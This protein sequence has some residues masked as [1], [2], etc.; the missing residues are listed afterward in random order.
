MPIHTFPGY[1]GWGYDGVNLFA[2]MHTYGTPDEIKGFI[3][4]AHKLGLGVILDVVYNHLGPEKNQLIRYCPHYLSED[5]SDWGSR[6]NFDVPAVREYCLTNAAYWIEEY[7]FDGLRFDASSWLINKKGTP[8][9]TDFAKICKRSG[10]PTILIAENERLFRHTTR[11]HILHKIWFFISRTILCM[12][13]TKSRS[14][15][16]TSSL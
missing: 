2:P 12:A 8:I 14:I 4:H 10:K 11:I 1:F 16:P 15:R 6:I 3:N 13:K 5:V 7:H 9:L